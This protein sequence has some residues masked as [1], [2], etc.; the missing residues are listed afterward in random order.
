MIVNLTQYL[1]TPRYDATAW[2]H[3]RIDEAPLADGPWTTIE[4]IAL[5]PLDADPTNPQPRS[6]SV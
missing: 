6:F 3:A 5:Y 2:T 1:P 4:T